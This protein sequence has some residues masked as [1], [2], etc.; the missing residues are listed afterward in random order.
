MLEIQKDRNCTIHAINNA[1]QKSFI[2]KEEVEESIRLNFVR[3]NIENERKN[4][5]LLIWKE[6]YEQETK[7]GYDMTYVMKVLKNKKI[8][9]ATTKVVSPYWTLFYKTMV[10]G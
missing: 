7:N 5:E 6:F 4:K 10:N 2:T 1:L 3:F 9:I 8:Y